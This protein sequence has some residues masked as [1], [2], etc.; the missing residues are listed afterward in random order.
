M[1]GERRL[2]PLTL[3]LDK[4]HE[5]DG[6]KSLRLMKPFRGT[7]VSFR[8]RQRVGTGKG[9]PSLGKGEI[10]DELDYS[11]EGDVPC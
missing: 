11:V 5:G 9:A 10:D 1:T 8:G 3:H 2:G 4:Q 6:H 7:F